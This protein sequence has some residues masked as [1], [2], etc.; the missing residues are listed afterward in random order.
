MPAAMAARPHVAARGPQRR[1]PLEHDLPEEQDEHARHVEA[2][3]EERPVAGVRL[4]LGLH[5]AD[6]EDHVVG[7]AREQVAAARAAVDEQ[8]A[9]R[10]VAALDLRA[11][12][13]RG[14]GHHRRRLL[15]DPA[16]R[17]DVLVRAEQDPGLARAGLRGEVGLPLGEPV[18]V[19][20]DPA[21]HLRRV[22]VAHRPPQH[23]QREPV[24]LE[25]DD[26]GHVGAHL[27]ALPA[28]DPLDDPQRVGVVVV[29]AEDRLQHDA[30]PP[31]RSAPSG[32]PSRRS[33]P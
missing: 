13:R 27:V 10:R 17:G 23:G 31:R 22:A 5:P 19:L 26:P 14:A 28:C 1:R 11:V 25:E 2:V 3:G 30:R 15:L 6:R 32:A 8:A 33:R 18:R 20:L 12:G 29:R 7:L 16:E 24:D 4:L 21:R 9:S